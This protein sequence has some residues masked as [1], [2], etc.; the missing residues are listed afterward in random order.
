SRLQPRRLRQRGA[1]G[2]RWHRG[3]RSRPGE[4]RPGRLRRGGRRGGR[5]R[6]RRTDGDGGAGP[7]GGG[8]MTRVRFMRPTFPAPADVAQDYE[9]IV[10]RGTFGNG[11]PTE[12]A[13]AR[14]LEGWVGGR[15]HAAL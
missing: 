12:L 4:H 1:G 15:V 14:A 2:F 7:A 8:A 13:F 10:A 9:A 11:G 6:A 5:G 3:D